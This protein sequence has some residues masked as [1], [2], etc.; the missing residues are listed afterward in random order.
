MEKTKE[1][2]KN[3]EKLRVLGLERM[4]LNLLH[5]TTKGRILEF[6]I[7][8][9]GIISI[10]LYAKILNLNVIFSIFLGFITWF[11]VGFIIDKTIIKF[12]RIDK[13]LDWLLKNPEGLR[14]LKKK[15]ITD[16]QIE[17]LKMDIENEPLLKRF[18]L[19]KK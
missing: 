4:T 5:K 12:Y 15:G 14:E 3:M 16:E 10:F 1:L 11:V 13:Q 19:E 9:I 2:E 8:F 7:I 6:I 17:K 18:S